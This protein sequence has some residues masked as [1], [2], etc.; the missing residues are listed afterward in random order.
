MVAAEDL[1][2]REKEA[3]CR[4][5]TN[6]FCDRSVD[7]YTRENYC[8]VDPLKRIDIESYRKFT[9]SLACLLLFFI[10]AP[11][12]AIIRKGGLGTP[13]I[14]SIFFFLVYYIIDI[15]GKKLAKDGAMTPFMGTIISSVVLLPIGI[16]LTRHA[17]RDS[18]LFNIDSYKLFF[19]ISGTI[20]SRFTIRCAISSA[21]T[22]VA[23][24]IIIRA[25]EFAAA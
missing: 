23:S 16:F 4:R 5:W 6:Q 14:I 25:L 10:G 2:Q 19:K 12:G 9:L 7:N 20:S 15:S 18:S 11:L 8:Y 13:V 22:E 1:V 21:R 17:I 3:R 24:C